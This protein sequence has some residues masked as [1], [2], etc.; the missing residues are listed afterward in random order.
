MNICK[1]KTYI[2]GAKRLTYKP[3]TNKNPIVDFTRF[4]GLL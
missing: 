2:P 1:S 3:K 4:G